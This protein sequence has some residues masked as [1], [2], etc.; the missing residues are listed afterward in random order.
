MLV[1]LDQLDFASAEA[2]W[3]VD[4]CNLSYQDAAISTH[5]TVDVFARRLHDARF[6]LIE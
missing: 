3:L 2:I 1:A 6:R 4:V 5:T